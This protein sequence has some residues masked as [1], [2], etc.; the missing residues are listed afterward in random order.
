MRLREVFPTYDFRKLCPLLLRHFLLRQLLLRT[1][2]PA[3]R[4]IHNRYDEH[5]TYITDRIQPKIQQVKMTILNKNFMHLIQNAHSCTQCDSNSKADADPGSGGISCLFCGTRYRQHHQGCKKTKKSE[6]VDMCQAPWT[7]Q[8]QMK[9]QRIVQTV[10]LDA[11]VAAYFADAEAVNAAL[12]QIIA[13]SRL[14][15][16]EAAKAEAVRDQKAQAQA[17]VAEEAAEGEEVALE[18]EAADA[19]EAAAAPEAEAAA[20]ETTEERKETL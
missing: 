10:R 11:D 17:A 2:L 16:D 6:F 15:K 9:P 12:R 18:T 13:I 14:V 5:G 3:E 19:E 8:F 1:N 20:G 4:K 7:V